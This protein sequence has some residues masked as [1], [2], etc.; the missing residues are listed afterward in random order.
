MGD[1]RSKNYCTI[2]HSNKQ[3]ELARQTPYQFW[4]GQ[5]SRTS[6]ANSRPGRAENTGRFQACSPSQR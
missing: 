4:L 1:N 6:A 2:D 3:K 5:V